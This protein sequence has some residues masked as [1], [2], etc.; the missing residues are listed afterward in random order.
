LWRSTLETTAFDER[1]IRL[2]HCFLGHE[3]EA[4]ARFDCCGG[5]QAETAA[6]E[7]LWCYGV[8][9]DASLL[10][11]GGEEGVFVIFWCIF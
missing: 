7:L 10:R 1:N 6:G 11:P 9:F 4:G 2:E 8:D 3:Q 5:H